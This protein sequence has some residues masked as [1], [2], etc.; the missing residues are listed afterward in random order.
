MLFFLEMPHSEDHVHGV[1]RMMDEEGK[2][3]EEIGTE[4]CSLEEMWTNDY[5]EK[6]FPSPHPNLDEI[7]Q[8]LP[9][10]N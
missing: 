10:S 6:K 5:N 3:I 4:E 2:R 9:F 7:S 8:T 1:F